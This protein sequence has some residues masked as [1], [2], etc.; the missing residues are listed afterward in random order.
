MSPVYMPPVTC[1]QRVQSNLTVVSLMKGFVPIILTIFLLAAAGCTT[2]TNTAFLITEVDGEG[3]SRILTETGVSL[4]QNEILAR[5]NYAVMQKVHRCFVV[6]LRYDS[7]NRDARQYLEIMEQFRRDSLR[8]KMAQFQDLLKKTSRT[9]QEDYKLCLLAQQ[10]VFIDPGN[11]E[12]RVMRDSSSRTRNTLV[13]RYRR[14]S[15]AALAEVRDGDPIGKRES[16]YMVALANVNKTLSI[17]P[18]NWYAEPAK[19]L[20]GEEM[21]DVFSDRVSQVER[22]IRDDRF[23][24]AQRMIGYLSGMNAMLDNSYDGEIEYLQYTLDFRWAWALYGDRRLVLA[25][26][27]INQAIAG[28]STS[29]ALSLR[30]RIQSEQEAEKTAMA[31]KQ[32]SVVKPA[33]VQAVEIERLINTGE[34]AEAHRIIVERLQ[35]EK[36]EQEIQRLKELQITI[37]DWL[38]WYYDLALAYYRQ[39]NFPRA[40]KLLTIVVD[41]DAG[42]EMATD[43]LEKARSKLKLIESLGMV[44]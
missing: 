27:K 14:R 11:P 8:E 33:G 23:E 18:G 5:E 32:K 21:K 37:N 42:Y 7:K 19:D 6:A 9:E 29:E 44:Q 43:Y 22:S 16:Y 2:I 17:D 35:K 4:Y 41:I 26:D 36:D 12:T 20:I 25:E 28:R 39:E 40:V 38:K 1:M 3:K 31:R 30:D 13:L 15:E 10:C 34:L 24:N